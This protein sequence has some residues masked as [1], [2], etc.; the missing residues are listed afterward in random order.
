[1][2]DGLDIHDRDL[3]RAYVLEGSEAAFAELA[4]RHQGMMRATALRVCGDSEEALDAVQ[5]SLIAFARRAVEIHADGGAGPWLHRAVTLEAMSLRRQRLKRRVRETEAMDTLRATSGGMPPEMVAELDGEIDRL[6][7]KD[8]ETILLHYFEGLTFRAIAGKLG[9]SE[10]AWQKRGT[11]ALSK[12]SGALR[13]RGIV[14]TAT[15]LGTWMAA[16]R[17]E[18]GATGELLPQHVSAGVSLKSSPVFLLIMNMK[19]ALTACFVGGIVI[20]YAWSERSNF[21]RESQLSV[22]AG[23]K[24]AARPVR[25]DREAWRFDIAQVAAAVGRYDS[26]GREDP[27]LESHLRALMFSVPEGHLDEVLDILREVKNAGRF[28]QIAAAFYARWAEINPEA[29]WLAAADSAPFTDSARRG[30][31]ITWLNIDA[32]T[33]LLRS[34]DGRKPSDIAI[35]RE[36]VESKARQEPRVAAALID[37]LAEVWPEADK[38]LFPDV[39]RIW[40]LADPDAAGEW[41]ASYWDRDVK[42]ALLKQLAYHVARAKGRPGLELA[43]RIDD[44]AMRQEARN[45][46]ARWWAISNGWGALSP[47]A[48]N[49]DLDLKAGFPADWKGGEIRAFSLGLMANFSRYYPELKAIAKSPEQLQEVYEGVI[50]GAGFSQPALVVDAVENVDPSYAGTQ[51]GRKALVS[52]IRRWSE[53]DPTAASA[54]LESQPANAKTQLMREAV[55]NNNKQ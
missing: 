37:R 26:L 30:V 43:D 19:I 31:L 47:K 16:A 32:E 48:S 51:D 54:W 3:L 17:A 42:N 6:P 41:V 38:R 2:T 39:A 21:S 11:R 22:Q 52:Y 18:A 25:P 49:P 44:P 7:E 40:A 15:G 5:R 10:A 53:T 1:M 13:R 29:A 33:A 27:A 23:T 12:L 35:L 45:S 50:S 9:G 24:E 14:A 20:S 28:Q 8:R 4:R 34:Q 36:F 46:A 55:S